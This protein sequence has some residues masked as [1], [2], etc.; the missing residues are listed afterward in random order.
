MWYTIYTTTTF[1]LFIVYTIQCTVNNFKS[2]LIGLI[3]DKAFTQSVKR[4]FDSHQFHFCKQ[5][6]R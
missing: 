3:T 4:G 5:F 2:G 6:V 1:E